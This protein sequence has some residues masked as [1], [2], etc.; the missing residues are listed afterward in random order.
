M[1][2]GKQDFEPKLLKVGKAE[3]DIEADWAGYQ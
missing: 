3:N 2:C 1:E